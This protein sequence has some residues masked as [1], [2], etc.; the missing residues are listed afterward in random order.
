[1]ITHS[2]NPLYVLKR[3][4][5]PDSPDPN[6]NNF[7][8]LQVSFPT[9]SPICLSF[10]L[11]DSYSL[12]SEHSPMMMLLR[13]LVFSNDLKKTNVSNVL[14][15]DRYLGSSCADCVSRTNGCLIGRDQLDSLVVLTL[16]MQRVWEGCRVWFHKGHSVSSKCKEVRDC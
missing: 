11:A 15:S 7:N 13:M 16:A 5:F 4:D 14:G 10:C 12:L 1:M 6:N 9:S 8:S 2:N 3:V